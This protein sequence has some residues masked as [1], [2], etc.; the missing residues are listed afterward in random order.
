MQLNRSSV[1]HIITDP[2]YPREYLVFFEHLAR[3]AP[4]WLKPGGSLVVMS[5]QS[6]LPE[7]FAALAKSGLMYRWTFSCETNSGP[8]TQIYDRK[9]L[10]QYKPLLWYVK[11]DCKDLDWTGD[12]I[13]GGDGNDKRFHRW[14]QGEVQMEEIV[15]RVSLR[16][17]V[18]LDPFCGGGTTGVAA[19]RLGRQFIGIDIDEKCIAQTADRL[20]DVHADCR[21]GCRHIFINAGHG[22]KFGAPLG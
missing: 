4:I 19:L 2:A 10:P 3:L 9:I 6:Y 21:I 1:H 13:K 15:R 14:G 5:G 11:G 18:I 22:R 8:R 12:V 20:N 7:V 16:G 17:Q